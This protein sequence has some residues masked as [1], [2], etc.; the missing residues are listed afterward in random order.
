MSVA[1]ANSLRTQPTRSH[2]IHLY[3]SFLRASNTFANYNFR[4]YVK[5]RTRDS[6]CEHKSETDPLKITELVQKAERELVVV[7]RQGYLN[8]LY[9][10]DRL[11]VE[12]EALKGSNKTRLRGWN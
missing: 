8:G 9:A 4:D 5:R 6:F 3:R 2:I 1:Y 7:K 11:V 10:V 12:Q